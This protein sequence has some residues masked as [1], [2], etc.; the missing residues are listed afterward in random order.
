MKKHITGFLENL[1]E[2]SEIF[3]KTVKS[4]FTKRIEFGN[5]L[6]QVIKIGN[7]S[8]ALVILCGFFT[9]M[10]LAL[11]TGETF[12]GIFNEPIYVGLVVGY[13]IILELGPVLTA[14]VVTGRAGAAM[15]AEIGTMKV[16]EQ[17]DALYTLG[18]E[19]IRYILVPRFLAF[20]I[21]LPFLTLFSNCAGILGGLVVAMYK[22]QVP[23]SKYWEEITRMGV[24]DLMH[25]LIKSVFFAVIIVWVSCFNGLKTSGGAEGVG[26]ATT[27]AVVVSMV[28]IIATDYFLTSLL[29][30]IGIG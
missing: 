14:I 26:K 23:F 9:G 24:E 13:A 28:L 8:V 15:T 20:M 18:T 7:Q 2:A 21:A 30:S 17:I 6:D 19:P 27:S 10:V 11:Q 22:L 16:T 1:G 5:T 12:L 4:V 25:G 29:I 3:Y